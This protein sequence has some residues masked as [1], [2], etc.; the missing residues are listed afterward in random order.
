MARYR[1]TCPTTIFEITSASRL[2]S[3]PTCRARR[4]VRSSVSGINATSNPRGEPSAFRSTDATVSE[5]LHGDRTAIDEMQRHLRSTLDSDPPVVGGLH[6]EDPPGAVDVA[7]HQMA[8]T[9]SPA[10]PP[11]R[12]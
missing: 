11:V 5:T 1:S 2:T 4:V 8:P 7:L 12:D 10:S 6:L 9:P 3:S